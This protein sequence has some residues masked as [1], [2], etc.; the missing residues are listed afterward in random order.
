MHVCMSV[1]YLYVCLYVPLSG[2]AYRCLY[3]C[4]YV[5]VCVY[6]C[7]YICLCV[8][9]YVPLA[10]PK[11]CLLRAYV[12]LYVCF[13]VPMASPEDCLLTTSLAP[14]TGLIRKYIQDLDEINS[15]KQAEQDKI[16]D[17]TRKV[18]EN[19]FYYKS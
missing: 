4:L 2:A 17:L 19:S 8:C 10:S 5:L 12:C 7:M 1:Y 16:K 6:V 3:L 11:D 18:H 9:L 15:S 13:Y 14:C